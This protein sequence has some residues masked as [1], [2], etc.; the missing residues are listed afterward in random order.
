MY[1]IILKYQV[2]NNVR[3]V[4]FIETGLMYDDLL[5]N[6]CNILIETFLYV[7]KNILFELYKTWPIEANS[8]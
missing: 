2:E 5:K 1:N 3:E 8:L 7:V 4:F 6:C